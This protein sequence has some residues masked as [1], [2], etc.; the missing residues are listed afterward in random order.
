MYQPLGSTS[1]LT[2]RSSLA[3]KICFTL[4]NR[5]STSGGLQNN[6]N[7][8]N[9]MEENSTEFLVFQEYLESL[10]KAHPN[11]LKAS[12]E[13]PFRLTT[14]CLIHE[15]LEGETIDLINRYL[16]LKTK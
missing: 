13:I 5:I 14:E 16:L 12:S 6:N 4:Y 3:N 8:C 10:C 9:K 11:P 2:S 1:F 15:E 7:L